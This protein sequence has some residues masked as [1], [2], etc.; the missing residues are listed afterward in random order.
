MSAG[1]QICEFMYGLTGFANESSSSNH[2]LHMNVIYLF[3]TNVTLEVRKAQNKV[4]IYQSEAS[5]IS[6]YLG[7]HSV[8][9]ELNQ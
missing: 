6:F 7:K 1:M 3:F 5:Y 2:I 8:Q 9:S 4:R